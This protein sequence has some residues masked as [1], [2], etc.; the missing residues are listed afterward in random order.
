MKIESSR[1]VVTQQTDKP[2]LVFI[3]L[4]SNPKSCNKNC[5]LSRNSPY[6]SSQIAPGSLCDFT[7]SLKLPFWLLWIKD[8]L[9]LVNFS[10]LFSDKSNLKCNLFFNPGH[11]NF[12]DKNENENDSWLAQRVGRLVMEWQVTNLI[13]RML[14]Q[15]FLFL[16]AKYTRTLTHNLLVEK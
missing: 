9:R 16:E 12:T 8:S 13:T 5:C 15:Q 14:S 7:D 1:Q 11:W 10:S 2:T 4:L 3:K 6:T